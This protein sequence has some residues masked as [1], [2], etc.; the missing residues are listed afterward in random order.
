MGGVCR[1]EVMTHQTAAEK[2]EIGQRKKE[3]QILEIRRS[4]GFLGS[5]VKLKLFAGPR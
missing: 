3:G 2:K 1:D 5:S 4:L